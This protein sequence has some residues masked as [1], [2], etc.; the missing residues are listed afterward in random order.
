MLAQTFSSDLSRL[1]QLQVK[2]QAEAASQKHRLNEDGYY[3]LPCVSRVEAIKQ[4]ALVDRINRLFLHTLQGLWDLRRYVSSLGVRA[5]PSASL[6]G[7][8]QPPLQLIVAAH[9]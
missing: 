7:L 2:P 6:L 4:A 5:C 9:L 3:D 8:T 1:A